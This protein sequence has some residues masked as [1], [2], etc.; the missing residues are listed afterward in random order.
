VKH[1]LKK[2]NAFVTAGYWG[3]LLLVTSRGGQGPGDVVRVGKKGKVPLRIKVLSNRPLADQADGIRIIQGGRVIKTIP[4]VGGKMKMKVK[5]KVTIDTKKD[6]WIVVEAFGQWPSMAMTNAIYLDVEPYGDWGA[7]SWQF[8]EGSE[9]WFNPFPNAPEI[10]VPDG[11]S[12]PPMA[13]EPV[14][15]GVYRKTY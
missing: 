8:P 1:S 15:P 2:G 10:T 11:P 6:T 13:I 7:D 4:T 3:P 14:N 5:T 12:E 9:N